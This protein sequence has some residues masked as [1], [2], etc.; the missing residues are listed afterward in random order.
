[1]VA[2][3]CSWHEHHERASQEIQTRLNRK[4]PMFTAAP[5]IIEAYS[6]LTRFPAPH[7]ISP[8]EALQLLET[9]FLENGKLVALGGPAYAALLRSSPNAA[10]SGGRIYDAV[11]AACARHAEAEILLTFNEAHFVQFAGPDLKIVVP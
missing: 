11:I 4:Q 7:R 3:V 6:V 9:N 1:M 5:A 8:T 2:A 10:V